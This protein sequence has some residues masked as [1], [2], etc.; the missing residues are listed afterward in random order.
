MQSRSHGIDRAVTGTCEWL[1]QHETYRSWAASDRG[2]LWIKGKPG[3]GKSTLVKYSL[4]NHGAEGDAVVLS[5]FFH[6]RG[7]ELQRIPLGLF[8]S[9]LHQ[10]LNQ[11]PDALQ[12]LIDVFETKNKQYGSLGRDWHW[13]EA[14]LQPFLESFLRKVVLKRRSVWLFI[15]ALDESG[16]DDAVRLVEIFQS[17]LQRLPS[18]SG[19][20]PGQVHICFSCRHYPVLDLDEGGFEIC[21][22]DENQRDIATFVD[23]QLAAFRAQSSTIPTL[24][25]ERASGVFMWARLVVKQ[26]LDLNREGAGLKKIQAAVH[27]VPPDL[28]ALYQ[29]LIQGMGPAS[30]KLIQWICFATEPLT[31]DELRWAMVIEGDCPH[32]SLKA[33]QSDEDYVPDSVRMKRQVQTLSRGLVEVSQPDYVQPIHQSV[34]DFFLEKG[35]SAL[36]GSKTSTEAALRAHFR[37]AKICIRYLAMEEIGQSRLSMWGVPFIVLGDAERFLRYATNS[38]VAHIQQCDDKSIPQ[39]DLLALFTWPSNALMERLARNYSAARYPGY[40]ESVP[41]GTSL[42]HITSTYGLLGLLTAILERTGPITTYIDARDGI[43]RTPLSCAAQEGREGVVKLLLGTGKVDADTKCNAGRTPLSRAAQTGQEAVVKLLLSTGK[44]DADMKDNEGKTPLAWAAQEGHNAVAELL[45]GTGKT[46]ADTRDEDDR[47]PLSWA[48]EGGHKALVDLLLGTSKVGADT[49]DNRGQT[50]LS[51]AAGKGHEAVVELLLSTGKVDADTKDNDGWT[52]LSSAAEEGHEA[53]V[54]LLLGTGKVDANTKDNHGQTPLLRA[55]KEGHEVV[56]ELLL[57]TNKVDIEARDIFYHQTPLSWAAGEGRE[58]V[59]KV[60]LQTGTIDVETRCGAF[61]QTPLSHAA[62]NGHTAVVKLLLSIGKADA[63][64][65]DKFRATPLSWAAESGHEAVVKI[66]LGISQ[67]D[68]DSKDRDGMTPLSLA[69]AWGQEAIVTLLLSIGE[70]D[71]DSKDDVG[72]T[73]LLWAADGGHEA[74]VKLLL[75]TGK[76]DLEAED[77]VYHRTP[78]AWASENGHADVLELLEPA[79]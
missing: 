73:P 61:G 56:V 18:Q 21:A 63:D 5:F 77:G 47:T 2:L 41:K 14:E 50:P 52:P 6:G 48:A 69:A 24:I 39:Q 60:L 58:A 65:R 76:V 31:L 62:R 32:R 4:D 51:W 10:A 17:L 13:H 43:G 8:R 30:L 3:S 36:D 53:V 37:L 66:L 44:V 57:G 38:W 54:E 20:A 35:L 34:K 71:A 12:D 15:D 40:R 64:S 27:S 72:R 26:V 78:W 11:A 59:V 29:Q 22:E 46:D 7:D 19:T 25:T 33:C 75:A 74:V 23:D 9:L 49:K 45:L 16:K 55:A 70:V 1:R 42:V 68:A 67:V 28:D 79:T